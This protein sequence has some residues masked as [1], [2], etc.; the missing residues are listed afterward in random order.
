[1]MHFPQF[2]VTLTFAIAC[3]IE[4]D[5]IAKEVEGGV[6]LLKTG[7]IEL[8]IPET[9]RFIVKNTAQCS[10]IFEV[11]YISD[12]TKNRDELR[13]LYANVGNHC[14]SDS[15]TVFIQPKG[16]GL[17]VNVQK[18]DGNF[19]GMFVD[20]SKL[21][22]PRYVINGR[23][24]FTV[25]ELPTCPVIVDGATLPKDKINNSKSDNTKWIIAVCVG[26]VT[27]VIVIVIIGTCFC[28]KSNRKPGSPTNSTD[29]NQG[30]P[31]STKSPKLDHRNLSTSKRSEQKVIT[32][33][34]PK[35]PIAKTQFK[36]SKQEKK[37]IKK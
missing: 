35:T 5:D 3:V 10:G 14:A 21:L 15:C 20:G 1:M 11:C 27:V 4:A 28:M 29:H 17:G 33:T 37:R 30:T 23:M 25:I 8:V 16:S 2:A 13:W 31:K 36:K 7:P 18:R 12:P 22:C 9:L 24:N 26:F 6:Q 19:Y 34:S 32:S